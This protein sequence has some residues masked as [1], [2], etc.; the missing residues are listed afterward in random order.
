M[1]RMGSGGAIGTF[2]KMF[3]YEIVLKREG[4]REEKARIRKI[5]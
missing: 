4:V 2:A 3:E 1:P 5:L